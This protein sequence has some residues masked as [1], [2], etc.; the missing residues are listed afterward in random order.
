MSQGQNRT[1]GLVIF[2][3]NFGMHTLRVGK[4]ARE[5]LRK[6]FKRFVGREFGM[7]Y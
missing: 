3:N 7:R 5:P 1:I 2:L 4:A 6:N